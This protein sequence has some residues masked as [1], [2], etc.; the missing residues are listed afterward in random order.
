M[1]L[2]EI[3][4]I[5]TISCGVAVCCFM[6][7]C[8]SLQSQM[9]S[10]DSEI[11]SN[12]EEGHWNAADRIINNA[13]FKCEP[14]EHADVKAWRERERLQ[15]RSFFAKSLMK[16][17]AEANEQYSQYQF[18]AGDKIR[19]SL[20]DRYFG[21][22]E[23]A[24]PE[25]ILPQWLA[26]NKDKDTG[27]PESLT[28][29]L[30]LAW[31]NMLSDRNIARMSISFKEC[32]TRIEGINVNGGKKSIKECDVIAND[33][34]RIDKWKDKIDLFMNMLADPDTARWAPIDRS[35]YARSIKKMETIRNQV[36]TQYKLKRWNTRVIDRKADYEKV[37]DLLEVKNYNAALQ[38]LSS[39]DL[40]VKPEGIE[41]V[42]DFDDQAER[43]KLASDGLGEHIVKQLFESGLSG[44]QYHRR[45]AR[46]SMLS[47]LI[48]GRT[49]VE[50]KSNK[51]KLRE[52]GRVAQMQA[53]S[54][55][56]RYMKTSIE[57][58][59][60][61]S[62]SLLDDELHKEISDHMHEYA[63]AEISNLM[64]LA[65]GVD[66]D[67]VVIILGWRDPD[68]GMITPAPMRRVA[69]EENLTISPSVGAYL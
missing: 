53:R 11:R 40:I 22:Q 44:V 2:I 63:Q 15:M 60:E 12:M 37:A 48:V 4:N 68:V 47:M 62:Q 55:F 64:V 25:T 27:I 66:G 58:K 8:T 1:K 13:E 42:F 51:R 36:C 57:V 67:E 35:T 43:S 59:S 49:L 32:L 18:T 38:I 61:S 34:R 19:Q 26:M 14:N 52:A 20:R 23:S 69:G 10:Y 21:G 41:G 31:V 45:T 24:E 65:T 54:E 56:V 46:R 28:P 30:T 17:V 39:H 16:T 5:G 50:D 9:G 33:F 6:T 3:K 7:A 29:C